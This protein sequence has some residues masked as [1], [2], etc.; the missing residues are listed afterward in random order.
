[1]VA[2]HTKYIGPTNTRWI[3]YKAFTTPD[4]PKVTITQIDNLS[5]EEN[6]KAVAAAYCRKMGWTGKLLSGGTEDGYVF[7]FLP[8][9][10]VL[11]TSERPSHDILEVT[12]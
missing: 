4:R 1:M 9:D 7:V 10:L 8:L 6:H 5:V 12:A 11:L 2:I 3:R